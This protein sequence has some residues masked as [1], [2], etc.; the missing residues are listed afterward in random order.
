[1]SI[2][3]TH[4]A[5]DFGALC[6]PVARRLWGEPSEVSGD[7]L[8]WGSHGSKSVDATRGVWF[9]HETNEGGGTVDLICRE[10]KCAAPDAIRWLAHEGFANRYRPGTNKPIRASARLEKIVA[11]YDYVDE[12]GTPLFEVVRF[13]PKDFRQRRP[14]G[15]R[16]INAVR[17]VLLPDAGIVAS[18]AL[19]HG[20][21]SAELQHAL[22]RNGKGRHE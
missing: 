15:E 8:R 22:S 18:L 19:Q 12:V 21:T 5:I 13:A 11:T 1:M 3:A 14:N 17:R 4:D 10:R 9:D 6:E 20:A 16:N 7:N 2:A